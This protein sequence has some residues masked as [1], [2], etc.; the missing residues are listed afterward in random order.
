M[1][2]VKKSQERR[3]KSFVPPEEPVQK[4]TS[5]QPADTTVNIDALKKKVQQAQVKKNKKQD[6][7][8]LF[9]QCHW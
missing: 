8:D 9:Y 3:A 7:K 5:Q 2:G 1:E 4:A 6:L